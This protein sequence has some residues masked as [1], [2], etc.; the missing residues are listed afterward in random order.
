MNKNYMQSRR[1]IGD[2]NILVQ[3]LREGYIG[4]TVYSFDGTSY[5]QSSRSPAY[6]YVVAIFNKSENKIY[7]GLSYSHKDESYFDD[8][9]GLD[10]AIERAWKNYNMEVED[11]FSDKNNPFIKSK[12]KA[13]I[14]LFKRRAMK[15]F[16]PEKYSFSGSEP[17]KEDENKFKHLHLCRYFNDIEKNINDKEKLKFYIKKM[18]TLLGI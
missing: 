9:Y 15:F 4:K 18:K 7:Y 14:Y 1:N 12:D 3:K 13:Q 16:M 8:K 6:G 11:S 10:L 2:N 17:L 5:I